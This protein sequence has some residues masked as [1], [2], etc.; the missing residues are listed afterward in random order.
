MRPSVLWLTLALLVRVPTS[1]AADPA[2][3]DAECQN[4][5][6]AVLR[7]IAAAETLRPAR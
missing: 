5:A 2:A 4:K 1:R 3:E 7:A 6:A